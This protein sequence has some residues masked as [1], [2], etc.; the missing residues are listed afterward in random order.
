MLILM[1]R[2]KK[3]QELKQA[4]S[5]IGAIASEL[6]RVM[7]GGVYKRFPLPETITDDFGT[8]TEKRVLSM[9]RCNVSKELADGRVVIFSLYDT[10]G[11]KKVVEIG[12]TPDKFNPNKG[13]QL[14]ID[15]RVGEYSDTF[16]A[17]HVEDKGRDHDIQR[18]FYITQA[19]LAAMSVAP[20]DKD[21]ELPDRKF[22]VT[23]TVKNVATL[24]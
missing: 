15:P 22:A 5:T 24:E 4:F 21:F 16:M 6:G 11:T 13:G 8:F 12:R 9:N 19:E 23:G 18:G 14:L 7:E 20:S 10:D 2:I 3:S 17:I 1:E